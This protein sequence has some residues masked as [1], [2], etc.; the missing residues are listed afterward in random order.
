MTR[1]E[2]KKLENV[3]EFLPSAFSGETGPFFTGKNIKENIWFSLEE[4]LVFLQHFKNIIFF[5][6]SGEQPPSGRED[7]FAGCRCHQRRRDRGPAAGGGPRHGRLFQEVQSD[8][9][10]RAPNR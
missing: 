4:M 2:E 3:Q 10:L 8:P 5:C 1:T 7:T 9:H 6:F